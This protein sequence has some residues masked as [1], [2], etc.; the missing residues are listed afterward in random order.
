[1]TGGPQPIERTQRLAL[2][3]EIAD[4]ALAVYQKNLLI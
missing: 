4:R 2:A 3:Q 1:M